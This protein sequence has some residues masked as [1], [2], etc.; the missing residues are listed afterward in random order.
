M[1]L[2]DMVIDEKGL[3]VFGEVPEEVYMWCFRPE[4]RDRKLTVIVGKT[5]ETLTI[6]DYLYK[7]NE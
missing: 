1:I 3:R 2:Y 5:A 7:T 4:N 6:E